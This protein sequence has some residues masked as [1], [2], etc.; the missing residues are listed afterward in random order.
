MLLNNIP[1]DKIYDAY[2]STLEWYRDL[3]TSIE[4]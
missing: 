2:I 4:A 3:F 1:L